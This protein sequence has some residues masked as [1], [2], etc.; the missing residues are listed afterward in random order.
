MDNGGEECR[1]RIEIKSPRILAR[2]V[3]AVE[4]TEEKMRRRKEI[5]EDPRV[6]EETIVWS[7][8]G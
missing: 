4:T 6:R 2:E 1:G 7:Q 5:K 3:K 8:A